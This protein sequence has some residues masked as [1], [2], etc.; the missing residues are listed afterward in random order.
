MGT[1]AIIMRAAR[2]QHRRAQLLQPPAS[3]V[4]TRGHDRC[5]M[6]SMDQ[7]EASNVYQGFS[8][9]CFKGYGRARQRLKREHI[10]IPQWHLA[11]HTK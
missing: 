2:L 4:N 7:E 9:A 3:G 5:S 1:T 8:S 11:S 10:Q 6:L